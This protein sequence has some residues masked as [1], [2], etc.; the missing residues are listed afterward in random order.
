MILETV[1]GVEAYLWLLL[2]VATICVPIGVAEFRVNRAYVIPPAVGFT[3]CI[4]AY[5]FLVSFLPQD[6][7]KEIPMSD[8]L[9]AKAAAAVMQV[10]RESDLTPHGRELVKLLVSAGYIR[11]SRNGFTG[12]ITKKAMIH[13]SDDPTKYSTRELMK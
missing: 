8:K 5:F 13:E 1:S 3:V 4:S 2:A 12:S 9:I 7:L 11:E 6:P 10:R